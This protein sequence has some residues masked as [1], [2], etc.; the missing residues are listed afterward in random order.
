MLAAAGSRFLESVVRDEDCAHSKQK[1]AL[2][3]LAFFFKHVCGVEDPVFQIKLRKKEARIPVVL[4]QNET[5]RIFAQLDQPQNGERNYGLAVRLQYG[6]GL[7]LSEL[8]RLRI[9]DMDV[10]R[11]TVTVR[12]GKGAKTGARCFRQIRYRW[13]RNVGYRGGII[14]TERSIME[15]LNV[16]RGGRGW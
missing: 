13:I 10:E 4:S 11:G 8:M 7:R 14:C 12:Q 2:N 15:R 1:Q 6:S 9:K 16:L 5:Q 3:A